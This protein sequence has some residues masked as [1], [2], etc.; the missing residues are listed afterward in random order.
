MSGGGGDDFL[1][2]DPYQFTLD[3]APPIM[4]A[5]EY[6]DEP[7][8][9]GVRPAST[10]QRPSPAAAKLELED[11]DEDE[12]LQE[13][14]VRDEQIR[15]RP[16]HEEWDFGELSKDGF[17]LQA[18]ESESWGALTIDVRKTLS[19]ADEQE[20]QRLIAALHKQKEENAKDMRRIVFKK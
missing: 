16:Q 9:M 10:Y 2:S 6:A 1:A 13:D 14:E 3:V 11:E 18:C 5:D 17:D 4:E 15:P 20:K 8:S 12:D 19:G 7:E